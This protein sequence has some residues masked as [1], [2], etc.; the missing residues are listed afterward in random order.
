MP[1]IRKFARQGH[2]V[3]ASATPARGPFPAEIFSANPRAV[4]EFQRGDSLHEALDN[5]RYFRC[6]ECG[7]T[8]AEHEMDDHICVDDS[9]E[10]RR[11]TH[12][13]G[14]VEDDEGLSLTIGMHEGRPL[15]EYRD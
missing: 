11:T 12:Y 13:D 8:I 4:E 3:P 15:T 14:Q 6:R 2:H 7:E 10:L 1:I 9:Y 5:I